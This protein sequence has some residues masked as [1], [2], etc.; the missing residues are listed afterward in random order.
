MLGNK[1]IPFSPLLSSEDVSFWCV[2]T[3]PHHRGFCSIQCMLV[4]TLLILSNQGKKREM[5][6]L[7]PSRIPGLLTSRVFSLPGHHVPSPLSLELYH[8]SPDQSFFGLF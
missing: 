3:G 7:Y 1:N 6:E 2:R 5:K 8:L 4:V